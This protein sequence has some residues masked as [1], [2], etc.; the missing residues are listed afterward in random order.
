[1][2]EKIRVAYNDKFIGQESDISSC[3]PL[4]T[5]EIAGV[6]IAGNSNSFRSFVR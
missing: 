3:L 1:M 6:G 4:Y 5:N 2:E